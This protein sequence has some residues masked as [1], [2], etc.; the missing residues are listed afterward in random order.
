MQPLRLKTDLGQYLPDLFNPL[1][2]PEVGV[3]SG[4]LFSAAS[5]E[6]PLC[7]HF[8]GTQHVIGFYLGYTEDRHYPDARPGSSPESCQS[9]GAKEPVLAAE[10]DDERL[11]I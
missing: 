1:P 7:T 4:T 6:N 5:N 2:N 11:V 10:A 3:L 9:T 8:E